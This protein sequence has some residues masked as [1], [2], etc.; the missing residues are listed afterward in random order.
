[1]DIFRHT[2]LPLS[3]CVAGPG[4]SM[5]A[6]CEAF[7]S[8]VANACLKMIHQM[9]LM[10]QSGEELDSDHFCVRLQAGMPWHCSP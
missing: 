6:G 5:D 2:L 4:K 8:V 7:H 1:V 9:Y 10:D 3:E